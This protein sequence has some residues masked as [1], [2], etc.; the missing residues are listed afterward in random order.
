MLAGAHIVATKSDIEDCHR[1][2]KNGSTILRFVNRKFCNDNLGKKFGL[3]KNI[4]KSILGFANGTKIYVSENF[5]HYNQCVAWKFRELKRA[6]NIHK[7]WSM[8]GVIKIRWSLNERPCSIFNDDGISY[9][10]PDFVLE[11]SNAAKWS[12]TIW[13]ES[14]C[15]VALNSST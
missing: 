10:F 13:I 1:L 12:F 9:V 8:K 15:F 2:G 6:K 3:H 7:V 5:T 14:F 4:D 11:E